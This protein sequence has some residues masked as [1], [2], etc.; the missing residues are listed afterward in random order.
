MIPDTIPFCYEQVNI[1]DTLRHF[2][3]IL[4]YSTVTATAV[5][6]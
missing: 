5:H 3:I 6:I 2:I 4:K 1:Y